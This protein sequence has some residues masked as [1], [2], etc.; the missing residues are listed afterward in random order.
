MLLAYKS[1]TRIRTITLNTLV[2]KEILAITLRRVAVGS[3]FG[4]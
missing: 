3:D 4:L 2:L 1:T